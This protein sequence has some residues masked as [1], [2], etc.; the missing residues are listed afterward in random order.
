MSLYLEK[1][2]AY[3]LYASGY[4][5]LRKGI[6]V[7]RYSFLIFSILFFFLQIESN[8]FAQPVI[9]PAKQHP[10]KTTKQKQVVK[11]S[12]NDIWSIIYIGKNRVGFIRNTFQK[13]NKQITISEE[14]HMTFRRFGKPITIAIKLNITAAA[15]G[16]LLNYRFEMKN[17]PAN[18][19]ISI[20]KVQRGQLIQNTQIAG[21]KKTSQQPLKR[22]TKAPRYELYLLKQKPLL[23]GQTIRFQSF[24]PVFNKTT[25]VTISAEKYEEIKLLD[26]KKHRLLR[27]KMV[28]SI[29]P[30]TPTKIW[31]DQQGNILR[32]E[33][34]FLGKQM[35]TYRVKPEVA[36]K[37][38]A[39]GELDLAVSALVRVN[40]I[41]NGHK[42]KKVVYQIKT[43]Q[44]NPV[45]YFPSGETQ[46]I[47]K[48]D[49]ETLKLTVTKIDLSKM[50]KSK[51]P[52][53]SYLKPTL[54]LQSRDANVRTHAMRATKN[55]RDKREIAMRMEK[56]V[57]Q[58]MKAKNFSTA[59]AS[60][61]EVAK[62][63]EGDCTEH[64]VLLAAMLRVEKIPSRIAVGL[65]YIEK[66]SVFSGHMWTE[67]YVDGHWIPLDA[68]L[69]Q[70]GIGAAHIK[71]AASSFS[72]NAPA[73]VTLFLP[74]MTLMNNLQIT[75]VESN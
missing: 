25:K 13:Q 43:P 40:Q 50:G 27:A 23:P 72:E 73:P 37:E 16:D 19:T 38:V 9:T 65:V 21:E 30:Q 74:M 69:G 32:S 17:S 31:I 36:L 70:G 35:V 1:L 61:A 59:L 6:C 45:K 7:M 33:S 2:T 12:D 22:L 54:F 4:H 58:N 64:A 66:R 34:K 28:F 56:Y 51:K 49:H 18:K 52:D 15:E 11:T 71:L 29:V 14:T 39:G 44:N 46:S 60:A 24:E 47:E 26:G 55:R 42:S 20:G 48:I 57:Y 75:V 67:A 63:L 41:R 53:G 62:N 5:T 3:D 8:V 10:S 68:T